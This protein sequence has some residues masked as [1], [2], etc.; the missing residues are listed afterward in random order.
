VLGSFFDE[1]GAA[2]TAFS[3]ARFADLPTGAVRDFLSSPVSEN[4]LLRPTKH[5][6]VRL[7][8]RFFRLERRKQ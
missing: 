3:A 1:N 6:E 8:Y 7:I 5:T 4:I 2:G